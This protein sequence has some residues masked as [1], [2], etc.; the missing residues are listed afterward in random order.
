MA[1]EEE[2][3]VVERKPRRGLL[4]DNAR[5]KPNR[6]W[7]KMTDMAMSKKEVAETMPAMEAPSESG[8]EYPWGLRI[9]LTN[10]ELEKLG[11]D[12]D[13]EIGDIVDL[14]AFACVTSVS[15]D[16]SSDGSMRCRVELQIEKLAIEAEANEDTG[17]DG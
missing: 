6:G 3:I 13:C 1:D 7:S 15:M 12:C 10:D 14:R 2:L 8:P 16:K 17:A 9:C 4:Y 5:S 11:L